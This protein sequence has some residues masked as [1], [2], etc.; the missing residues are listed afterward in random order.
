MFYRFHNKVNMELRIK[1]HEITNVAANP[2]I[3][4]W[5]S[6]IYYNN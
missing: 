6:G 2:Y 3:Q 5:K 4:S 1:T